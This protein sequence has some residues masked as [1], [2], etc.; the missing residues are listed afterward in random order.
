M[1]SKV[2]ISK[3]NASSVDI[4]NVI[5]NYAPAEYQSLVPVVSTLK[6]LNQVGQVF[7][8]YPAMANY[9]VSALVNR[10]AI[11]RVKSAVF[12][13]RF[14][15]LKKGYLEFG[16][17]IE[18]IFVDIAKVRAFDPEKAP[19][20]EFARTLPNVHSQFHTINWRVQYPVTIQ[21]RDLYQAFLSMDGVTDLIAKIVD[22]VYAAE[23]YDEYLL[24]KYLLIKNISKNNIKSRIVALNNTQETAIDLRALTS[25]LEFRKSE[26]NAAGVTNTTPRERQTIFMDAMYAARFDV[27]VLAA[28]F[29]MDKATFLAQS[30][31]IDDWTTFDNERFADVRRGSDYI[32]E[33]TPAELAALS[34]VKAVICDTDWFQVY[35]NMTAFT[36]TYVSSGLYWNYFLNIYKTISWSIFANAVCVRDA[37]LAQPTVITSRVSQVQHYDSVDIVVL[38]AE[39]GTTET[40]ATVPVNVGLCNYRQNGAATEAGIAV[41]PFGA[42]IVPK[43]APA[44]SITLEM[45]YD[46]RTYQTGNITLSTLNV[47]DTVAFNYV[48]N[49]PQVMSACAPNPA[50]TTSKK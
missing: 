9:F 21:N 30:V 26:F 2:A 33:V 15:F 44:A 1:P 27:E 23:E 19:Q 5:R 25:L 18:D 29:N 28:A 35:D 31:M 17:T 32:E 47:G 50:A 42:Y 34:D 43:T 36:E 39:N 45:A 8:G 7:Q 11:V 6:D 3:L 24:F 10:I 20:R 14:A 38:S 49:P 4:V 37:A 46:S 16:E 12:H 48:E 22:S 41:Q 40:R 13:N